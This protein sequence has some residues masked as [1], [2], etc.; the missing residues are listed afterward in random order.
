MFPF[1]LSWFGCKATRSS[2]KRL[3]IRVES[4]DEVAAAGD[5]SRCT[6]GA[7]AKQGRVGEAS[8]VAASREV[9]GQM[10]RRQL[11]KWIPSSLSLTPE[12]RMRRRWQRQQRE[13]RQ[14]QSLALRL[15]PT[16]R[17]C[18]MHPVV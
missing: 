12:R 15:L 7:P 1:L 17:P 9:K 2:R 16:C 4:D 5:P 18:I 13:R 6:E 11:L 10:W 3:R 14:Q 8:D